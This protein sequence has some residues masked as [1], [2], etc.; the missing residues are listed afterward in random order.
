MRVD[1]L[2]RKK[3]THINI[4][5]ANKMHHAWQFLHML[6]KHKI[7]L[8]SS[9]SSVFYIISFIQQSMSAVTGTTLL[10]SA[11]FYLSE[12]NITNK[13]HQKKKNNNNNNNK[14]NV[15][16]TFMVCYQC[17][18]QLYGIIQI[19]GTALKDFSV[20]VCIT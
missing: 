5:K 3:G 6:A 10:L 17:Q 15:V 9:F 18:T 4:F 7:I 12:S 19:Q 20:R 11:V 16:E 14:Q 8:S 2:L 1:N 13:L